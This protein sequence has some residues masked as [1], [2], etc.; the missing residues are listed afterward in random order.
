[1]VLGDGKGR[2]GDVETKEAMYRKTSCL[3]TLDKATN[4][5][6]SS[7]INVYYLSVSPNGKIFTH[8]AFDTLV[9][10]N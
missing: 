7:I 6:N 3:D 1:M 9:S 10:I 5:A 4:S 8:V 2:E